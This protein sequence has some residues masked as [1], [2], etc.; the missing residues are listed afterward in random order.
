V[1]EPFF[2][3]SEKE[4]GV[5]RRSSDPFVPR[6]LLYYSP[7]FP[8]W[9]FVFLVPFSSLALIIGGKK[10]RGA[11]SLCLLGTTNMQAVFPIMSELF[12]NN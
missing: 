12:F 10:L 7:C 2:L 6:P 8:S 1:G 11:G 5:T 3:P 9:N 4:K